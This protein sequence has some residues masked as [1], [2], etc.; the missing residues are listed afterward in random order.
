[1]LFLAILTGE[2]HQMHEVRRLHLVST[3]YLPH[4]ACPRQL[5]PSYA[6]RNSP[7]VVRQSAVRRSK[8][9]SSVIQRAHCALHHSVSLNVTAHHG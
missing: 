2:P 7:R 9:L 6:H 3:G 1:M 5:M 4:L 8:T